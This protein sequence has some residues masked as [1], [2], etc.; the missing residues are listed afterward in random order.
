M[1][2]NKMK[3]IKKPRESI[4]HWYYQYMHILIPENVL[5]CHGTVKKT[6]KDH[7]IYFKY[8]SFKQIYIKRWHIAVQ[9]DLQSK[10]FFFLIIL[11][12]LFRKCLLFVYVLYITH[13][14]YRWLTLTAK[15]TKL[16]LFVN[17]EKNIIRSVR[18]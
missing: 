15:R 2:P 17:Y 6:K 8:I 11:S 16:F 10:Q 13:K 3:K 7:I 14:E 1:T 9:I 5:N 18:V 12:R 4:K